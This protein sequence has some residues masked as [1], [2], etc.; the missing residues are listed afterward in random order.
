MAE[1][2]SVYIKNKG[3]DV[4]YVTVIV[5]V[6]TINVKKGVKSVVEPYYAHMVLKNIGVRFVM[7]L[8]Y[9][10]IIRYVMCVKSATAMVYVNISHNVVVVRGV[11]VQPTVNIV[12]DAVNVLSVDLVVHVKTVNMHM[13]TLARDLN[14]TVF[15][16]I[17]YSILRKRYLEG[18][19]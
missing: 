13:Y 8:P 11:E 15:T 1:G 9:V 10:S 6:S 2:Q 4:Q 12:K 5:Y 7:V 3:V 14:H 16:V 18:I 19:D 17:V